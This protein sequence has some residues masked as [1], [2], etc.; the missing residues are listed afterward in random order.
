MFNFIDKKFTGILYE[1]LVLLFSFFC[2]RGFVIIIS[3]TNAQYKMQLR[4]AAAV[5]GAFQESQSTVHKS[6]PQKSII[7]V[8]VI[9]FMDFLA[10]V[11]IIKGPKK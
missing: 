6:Y 3:D 4:N 11:L 5:H 10:G 1:R 9:K 2:M 7:W 8:G